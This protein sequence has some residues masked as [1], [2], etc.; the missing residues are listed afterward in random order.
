MSR[1][2]LDTAVQWAWGSLQHLFQGKLF[3]DVLG[4]TPHPRSFDGNLE[5]QAGASQA[6]WARAAHVF[7]FLPLFFSFCLF[8]FS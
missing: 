6:I 4:K 5:I 1:K 3:P 7:F 8:L 2:L